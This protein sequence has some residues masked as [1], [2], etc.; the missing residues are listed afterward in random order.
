MEQRVLVLGS[1]A[2]R[3]ALVALVAGDGVGAVVVA[4]EAR[5]EVGC[6]LLREG[7]DFAAEI[8]NFQLL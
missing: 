6:V 3:L 2:A 8:S 4:A 5:I 1:R 7:E